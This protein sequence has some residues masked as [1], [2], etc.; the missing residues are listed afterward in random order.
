MKTITGMAATLMAA[1]MAMSAGSAGAQ[2]TI[3][4]KVVGNIG[5]TT[6]SKQ[7]ERPFWEE[8]ITEVSD[9]RIQ[10]EFAPWNEMGLKGP[11]VFRL[12]SN[13]VMDIANAQAAA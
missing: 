9:G 8:E 6:Q 5:I 12:L 1:G 11:E 4:L 3:E 13:G 7:I 10:A 2:D